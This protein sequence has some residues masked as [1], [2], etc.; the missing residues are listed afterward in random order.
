MNHLIWI[1]SVCKFIYGCEW[2]FKSYMWQF[3]PFCE[4]ARKVGAYNGLHKLT[5]CCE[6]LSGFFDCCVFHPSYWA[7]ITY[8]KGY[9]AFYSKQIQ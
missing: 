8:D 7:Q 5:L 6:N 3:I 9:K 2:C 4:S 1:Y